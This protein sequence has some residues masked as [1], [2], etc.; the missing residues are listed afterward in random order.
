MTDLLHIFLVEPE[1]NANIGAVARAMKNMGFSHLHLVAPPRFDPVRAAVT[2]CGAGDILD[3]C[4]IHESLEDAL[5][6]MEDVI[7]FSGRQGKN[8]PLR[9]LSEWLEDQLSAP[10][11]STALVFGPE[12]TG[13]H[14]KHIAHCRWLVRIPT[15]PECSSLN[16]AQA[17]LIVLYELSKSAPFPCAGR[18]ESSPVPWTEFSHLETLVNEVLEK[19]GFYNEGT[20]PSLPHLIGNLF[21]RAL[22]DDREMRI[23][24]GIFGRIGKS[25]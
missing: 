4:T 3:M 1:D 24:Q 5:A 7:G 10:Y 12:E 9:L 2:A 6:P 17:V 23:L 14:E 16:L 25:L 13:L 20:P 8:R 11:R 19:S 15:N 18:C 22:P 21:R